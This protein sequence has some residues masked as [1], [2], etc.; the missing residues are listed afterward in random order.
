MSKTEVNLN[1]PAWHL[2]SGLERQS[3]AKVST[4]NS[5]QKLLAYVGLVFFDFLGLATALLVSVK[6]R[7]E[8]LPLLS[9]AFPN[10]LPPD[11]PQHLWWIG[12]LCL[13]CLAWEG[14]YTRRLP[15]WRETRSMLGA[16]TLA[17]L[18]VFAV[19]SLARLGSEISRTTIV[20]GYGLAIL[21]VPLTRYLG[22]ALLHSI[23]IWAQPIIIIGTDETGQ[24]IASALTR[25]FYLGYRLIGFLDYDE[26]SK[27]SV[28]IKSNKYPI[29]GNA[30]QAQN[31]L[32]QTGVRNIVV[33]LPGLPGADLVQLTNQLRP[34]T[35]SILLVPD[36]FGIPGVSGEAGYF[37]NEQIL[38][39][40]TRNNLASRM[41]MLSKRVFDLI[42][43]TILLVLLVPVLFVIAALIMLETRG[44]AGFTHQRV[45][46]GGAL[47]KCY[48]FR[49]MVVNSQEILQDLLENDPQIRAEWE[50]DFKLK[51][52]PRVTRVGKFLRKTSLDE[53]PQL[54]NVLKGE[55]SLVGPRPIIEDE[56]P[57]FGDYYRE[58]SM[59]LPGMT[60]LWVV[61][62][63]SDIDYD[64]RVRLE[65]W[66]V[67]NW[68]MWLDMTLI[69]RTV[70]VVA[71]R[72]GAY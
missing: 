17:F 31:I 19:V 40:Q 24:S 69:F 70:G 61:S 20:L 26:N 48:K 36:L 21:L 23:G 18:L 57:R 71:A 9:P 42:V 66:Y 43:G 54:F 38:A 3:L 67:R 56:I 46:R 29:L 32:D 37:F 41:N 45:G 1:E 5:V 2:V 15:F 12:T 58:Y 4:D 68:S 62:G 53:L 65:S 7:L 64:E 6:I 51:D 59:V 33:A 39:F 50:N 44:P 49:T 52:D 8:I 14:L 47:F 11:Q 27:G 25:D 55:M 60:G 30:A 22:K 10:Y 35:R 34:F 63:R 13:I 28:Q 72:K 16:L